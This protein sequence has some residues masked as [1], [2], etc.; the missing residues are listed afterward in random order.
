MSIR[1]SP[2]TAELGHELKAKALTNAYA[3]GRNGL[4]PWR[5]VRE[6]QQV[7]LPEIPEDQKLAIVGLELADG[8]MRYV[9]GYPNF[10]VITKWNNSNRYAMAV[11]ELAAKLKEK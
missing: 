5:E 10:Q 8:G 1:D 7:D 11:I 6:L 4:L 3:K 2:L 9:A